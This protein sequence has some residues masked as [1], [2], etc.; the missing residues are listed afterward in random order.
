MLSIVSISGEFATTTLAYVGEIW[1]DV[2]PIVALAVGLPLAFYVIRRI[3][4][5]VKAR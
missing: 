4:G 2:V 3:I 1:T 5:L